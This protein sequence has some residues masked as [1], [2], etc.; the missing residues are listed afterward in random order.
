[1]L[2]SRVFGY[3]GF[4]LA[5]FFVGE[6]LDLQTRQL[7]RRLGERTSW[8][9]APSEAKIDTDA[10]RRLQLGSMV[11]ERKTKRRY[12]VTPRYAELSLGKPDITHTLCA[13]NSAKRKSA[14][15]AAAIAANV[16]SNS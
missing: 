10:R 1:M 12:M 3:V 16:S 5:F 6:R 8:Q 4:F 11:G 13:L 7:G 14:A 2:I 15:E 9:A